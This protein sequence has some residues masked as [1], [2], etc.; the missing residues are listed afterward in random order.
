[1]KIVVLMSALIRCI[2][3]I[4]LTIFLWGRFEGVPEENLSL[5]IKLR[6]LIPVGEISTNFQIEQTVNRESLI[7]DHLLPDSSRVCLD[8][9]LANWGGRSNTG[10]FA[11]DLLVDAELYTEIIPAKSVEDNVFHTICFDH[12]YIQTLYNHRDMR[13]IL[14]G[15]SSPNGA[16]ITAWTTSDLSA[17]EIENP[18]PV[19]LNRS[20]VFRFVSMEYSRVYNI[21]ALVLLLIGMLTLTILFS[22]PISQ[23]ITYLSNKGRVG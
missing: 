2:A 8:L 16:A 20:L 6:D 10:S 13:L 15:I 4:S 11:V 23:A 7:M 19:L 1:M 14:R 3:I 9:L 12:L 5:Q 21:H 18:S 17:G 22:S